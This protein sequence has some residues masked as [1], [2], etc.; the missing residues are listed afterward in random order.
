[1]TKKEAAYSK[2]RNDIFCRVLPPGEKI[3]IN[4]LA[5]KYQMSPIPIREALAF[6]ETE[7]LVQSEPYRGYIVTQA[8]F[9]DLIEK[10][11]ICNELE[12]LAVRFGVACMSTENLTR[13]QA[14]QDN[15]NSL[16][17]AGDFSQYV[18]SNRLFHESL[19]SFIPCSTLLNMID[20]LTKKSYYKQSILLMI[21]NRIEG[22]MNEHQPII[23]AIA[24][25]N[26]DLAARLLFQHRLNTLLSLIQE[27]KLNLMKAN[28]SDQPLLTTLFSAKQLESRSSVLGEVEYWNYNLNHLSSM[29][30][31]ETLK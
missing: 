25:H 21:P 26:P 4:A 14:L 10:S 17:T 9:H 18:I 22:S 7:N 30:T 13:T 19:Y 31:R 11:L 1:M 27:I 2:I 20:D 28:Y 23:D 12:C 16:F 15:L 24:S 6:L 3:N 29:E 8:E 5:E